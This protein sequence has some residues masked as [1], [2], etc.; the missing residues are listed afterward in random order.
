MSVSELERMKELETE[1]AK[2]QGTYAA[3]AL[4]RHMAADQTMVE[5]AVLAAL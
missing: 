1:N 5:L 4:R 3:R 2:L